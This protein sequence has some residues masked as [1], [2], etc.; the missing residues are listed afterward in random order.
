MDLTRLIP[1]D[2]DVYATILSSYNGTLWPL[3]MLALGVG[4]VVVMA[5]LKPS[6]ERHRAAATVLAVFWAWSGVGFEIGHRA[7][8]D[9][10]AWPLGVLCVLQALL[11]TWPG[12]VRGSLTFRLR[13]NG[14]GIA[15]VLLVIAS[16][17]LSPLLTLATGRPLAE[18]E[19]FGLAP[20]AA[21]LFMMALLLTAEE[22]PPRYL[23]PIP[24][25]LAL[26]ELLAAYAIGLPAAAALPLLVLCSVIYMV[27]FRW[28]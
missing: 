20:M 13:R 5:T 14:R 1:I 21:A 3:Q 17:G 12:V 18:A 4:I 11:L 6:P 7:I 2:R 8:Y 24:L 22:R 28:K 15:A 16:A 25:L 19:P 27:V 23:L 10:M 9:F 26:Y